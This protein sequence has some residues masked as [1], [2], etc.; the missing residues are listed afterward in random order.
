MGAVPG[1]GAVVEE[2]TGEFCLPAMLRSSWPLISW[3]D[4]DSLLSKDRS[5][6]HGSSASSS[7]HS[8]VFVRGK[9]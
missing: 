6:P 7:D 8:N 2:T 3:E 4:V 5:Q 9:P 1:M